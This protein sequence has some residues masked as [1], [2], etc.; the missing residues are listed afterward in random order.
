[1]IVCI[2]ITHTIEINAYTWWWLNKFIYFSLPPETEF[3][4]SNEWSGFV[5]VLYETTDLMKKNPLCLSFTHKY[6]TEK[7]LIFVL[8]H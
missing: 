5:W 1:M 6:W 2:K 7:F 8:Y 3:K 4:V